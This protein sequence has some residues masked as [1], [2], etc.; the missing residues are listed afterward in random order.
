MHRRLPIYLLLDCSES[1]AGESWQGLK[2]G[3][4]MLVQ[5]LQSDPMALE[6]AALSVITF[7]SQA[8]QVTPLTDIIKLTQPTLKMG[9]GTALGAALRLWLDAMNREVKATTT[10]QKGDYKPIC[11][12]LTDGEPTD[13]WEDVADHVLTKV[14]GRKANVVAFGCGPDAD[15]SKL[16]RVT[17]S[18][19]SL[20]TNKADSFKHLFS[21]VSASVSTASM[22]V[23][24]GGGEGI[25]LPPPGEGMQVSP[26]QHQP[27]DSNRFVFLHSRCTRDKKFFLYRFM[28]QPGGV[29]DGVNSHLVEDSEFDFDSG[30]GELKVASDS[31]GDPA[32]CPCCQNPGWGMCSQGHVHCTPEITG[33]M[34]LTCPWCG[35]TDTYAAASFDV[36]RGAG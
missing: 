13:T 23:S 14:L 31:L 32:P 17:E 26:T 3:M 5:E 15:L 7:A 19:I 24:G 27:P 4:Q 33:R 9:S 28:K 35:V 21:W 36:G 34:E 1:M 30:P 20:D 6:T 18:V 22:G 16:R 2:S 12:I 10:D 29:Y 8:Q 25:A 11:I